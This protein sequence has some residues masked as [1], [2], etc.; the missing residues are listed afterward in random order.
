MHPLFKTLARGPPW[1][2]VPVGRLG[3]GGG[4]LATLGHACRMMH[5]AKPTP[6]GIRTVFCWQMRSFY[7]QMKRGPLARQPQ[8]WPDTRWCDP[9]RPA[10]LNDGARFASVLADTISSREP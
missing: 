6:A 8:K 10:G 1:G 4:G 3:P 9:V 5:A 2:M 7:W